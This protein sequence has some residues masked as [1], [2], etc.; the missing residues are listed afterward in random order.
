MPFDINGETHV[1]DVVV[2]TY[3]HPLINASQYAAA[4]TG[5]A[6]NDAWNKL[7]V[8]ANRFPD[9]NHSKRHLHEHD[10]VYCYALPDHA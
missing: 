8:V 4:F 10:K 3:G 5:Y 6:I 1:I 7:T 2:T 9:L